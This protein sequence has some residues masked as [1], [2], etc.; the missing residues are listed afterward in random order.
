M[1]FNMNIYY[2]AKDLI[3]KKVN[4]TNDVFCRLGEN[5]CA[6]LYNNLDT[7][8]DENIANEICKFISNASIEELKEYICVDENSV[9]YD[10]EETF[11]CNR[12]T[13]AYLVSVE[14]DVEKLVDKLNDKEEDKEMEHPFER[15][16]KEIER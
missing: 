11:C 9:R 14:F 1:K 8:E 13:L 12:R 5:D 3:M 4:I 10:G 16:E 15:S 6:D 2:D 7:I